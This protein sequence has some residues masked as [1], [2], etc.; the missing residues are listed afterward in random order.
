MLWEILGG[1]VLVVLFLWPAVRVSRN[2]K[3]RK[4]KWP[5]FVAGGAKLLAGLGL[6]PL[7]VWVVDLLTGFGTPKEAIGV[8]ALI[9]LVVA[10]IIVLLGMWDGKMDEP[11]QWA[12]FVLAALVVAL[13][14]NGGETM[15][16]IGDQFNNSTDTI[17]AKIQ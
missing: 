1:L 14:M 16:Y 4:K 6:V 10:V 15:K 17:K 13:G 11:E 7:T 9:G 12:M 8:F 2:K 5:G 3:A